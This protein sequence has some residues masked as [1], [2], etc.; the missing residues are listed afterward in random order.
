MYTDIPNN[1]CVWLVR[2]MPVGKS[3]LKPVLDLP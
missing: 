2:G 1:I 3:M